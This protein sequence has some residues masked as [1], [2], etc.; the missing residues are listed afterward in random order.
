MGLFE[1]LIIWLILGFV[2]GIYLIKMEPRFGTETL[3]DD[4]F[5]MGFA[6]VCGPIGIV[7]TIIQWFIDP[8]V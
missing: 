4:L 1:Y 2:H 7:I 3:F 6:T 8:R 5:M